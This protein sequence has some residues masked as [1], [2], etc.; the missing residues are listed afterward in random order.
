MEIKG[1][2]ALVTGANRGIGRAFARALL[3]QGAAKVY[4]AARNPAAVTDA[5]VVPLRLDVTDATS[6][7]AAA[8]IAGDVSIV[9]NNA[10]VG[11]PGTQL[12]TGPFD[13]A[14]Q[15]M[16]VN[17]FGTWAVARAFAPILAGKGGGAVVNMLS[18][19]SWVGQ[20]QFP[21]Y[22]ASKAAQW[23]LT[24]ALRKGLHAQGTLVIGV[25]TGFV[26]TDLSAWTDAPKISPELVAALT[27][28]ALKH[29]RLE[30]L[31]DEQTRAAKAA[32]S[33]PMDKRSD[34]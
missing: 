8:E 34:R 15:A 23:S 19:A 5:D 16:D 31:A 26:D 29:D 18:L 25:H 30:V 32:L 13:G 4:A 28:D 11:A 21:G 33:T 7:A 24:D 12:L 3:A 17:Y 27:M 14:R 22:A 9:I 20:P 6:V 10:G 2:V 1:A